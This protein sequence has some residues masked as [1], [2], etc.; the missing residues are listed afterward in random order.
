MFVA[1][2]AF[3]CSG[4][5]VLWKQWKF[6]HER[7]SHD[8]SSFYE[9]LSY[10][11]TDWFTMNAYAPSF[12]LIFLTL[13][14]IVCGALLYAAL[15]GSSPAYALWRIF[16]WSTGSPAER[17]V[18]P[19]GRFL[20]T[21]VT[22]CGLII[23]SLLLGIVTEVFS[24]KMAEIKQ[25]LSRVVE[26]GHV[27]ILGFTE[28]T[29]CLLEEL[30][31]ARE[32]EGGGMFVILAEQTKD[33]VESRLFGTDL[34]I[35]NSRI[36]VRSGRSCCIRD[37]NK[38]AVFSAGQIVILSDT[39]V[40]QEEADAKSI[41]TLLALKTKGW[42]VHGRI[43]MQCASQANAGLFKS[44]YHEK[45][46]EVVVVGNIV[47][48]L[49]AQS[50]QEP[51]LS[52]VFSMML[53]FDGDE[54]YAEEWE[55]LVG[56]NFRDVVF[57]MPAAVTLGVFTADGECR[58]NPGWDYTIQKGD[59]II[60]LAEDNDA[61]APADASFCNTKVAKARA[62]CDDSPPKQQIGSFSP[63]AHN[64]TTILII[65]WN[66]KVGSLL[67]C[68]DEI[69]AYE[70]NVVIYSP[71]PVQDREDDI[72]KLEQG[73][74][75]SFRAMRISHLSVDAEKASSRLEL[76]RLKH[77][78]HDSIFILAEGETR[79][80]A[81]ERT[82]AVLAQ[83]SD[84]DRSISAQER[85]RGKFDPVVEM[86][87]DSTADHLRVCGF[88]NFV[89]SNSLV[90]QALAAVTEE[91]KV[92]AIYTELMTNSSNTFEFRSLED[93]IEE[94]EDVPEEVSF[95]EV[96]LKLSEAGDITLVAWSIT[97]ED[98]QRQW[99]MNP[100]DKLFKRRW[101]PEDRLVVI[102]RFK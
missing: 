66:S 59:Q 33:E 26:G 2:G 12:V 3:V 21:V 10:K 11:F 58:L 22:I 40:S 23:L 90:S 9:Y 35:R 24:T 74:G 30:A 48:R 52:S 51:G 7:V 71:H 44:L 94:D 73:L 16:V 32:S 98:G 84:I 13:G 86:C 49:M 47:A 62:M 72:L 45:D 76:L 85:R 46:V 4:M 42:P 100:K 95:G 41:R 1:F 19:G 29:H 60:V 83:L 36:V 87:E 8:E 14:L 89:H 38:V 27:V 80:R 55:E 99:E 91:P 43:V 37:L 28:C 63:R 64:A 101:T 54:F 39:S 78:E 79:A 96:A 68:L 61:Y 65:G 25:G 81:D 15:V 97:D 56:V 69:L 70:S 17:E 18:S 5:P 102:R 67:V 75:H 93:F 20:G 31:N 57:R 88:T 50:S 6:Y 34:K 53:G 82:M 77:Y 92:N